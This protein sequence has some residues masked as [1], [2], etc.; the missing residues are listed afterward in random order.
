MVEPCPR[1]FA[2]RFLLFPSPSFRNEARKLAPLEP[3]LVFRYTSSLPA[4]RH[5]SGA[6]NLSI[7]PPWLCKNTNFQN[8]INEGG[9]PRGHPGSPGRQYSVTPSSYVLEIFATEVGHDRSRVISN[10]AVAMDEAGKK[11][12][13]TVYSHTL[14]PRAQGCMF[15]FRT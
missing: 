10:D 3:A 8:R 15:V 7:H 13:R 9:N 1:D 12:K 2:P 11:K 6:R 5:H 14:G 4:I